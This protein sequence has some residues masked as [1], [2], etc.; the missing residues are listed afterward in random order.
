MNTTK[1]CGGDEALELNKEDVKTLELAGFR[2]VTGGW[3]LSWG[4]GG[5]AGV[6]FELSIKPGDAKFCSSNDK[7][8]GA[9][10]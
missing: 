6:A 2:Q 8:T 10:I 3:F 4:A 5:Q 7:D 1:L 9:G